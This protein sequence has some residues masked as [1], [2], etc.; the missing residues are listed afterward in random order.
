MLPRHVWR[1]P[2]GVD[3][4][5]RGRVRHPPEPAGV[6]GSGIPDGPIDHK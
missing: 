5:F 2:S 1:I 3:R 6:P 4:S